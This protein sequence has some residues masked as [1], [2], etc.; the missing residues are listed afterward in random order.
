MDWTVVSAL[1]TSGL[2]VVALF[3]FLSQWREARRARSETSKLAQKNVA[4]AVDLATLKEEFSGLRA[5][6]EQTAV[7][8]SLRES[9]HDF[10]ER[11]TKLED[12]IW[13]AMAVALAAG[14]HPVVNSGMMHIHVPGLVNDLVVDASL[15]V[16]EL[17]DGP[18]E[19]TKLRTAPGGVFSNLEQAIQP[20]EEQGLVKVVRDFGAEAAQLTEKGRLLARILE[21]DEER[22]R[23]GG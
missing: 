20:A 17:R 6:S 19:I 4:S 21:A 16:S 11:V 18:V 1:A 12:S 13:S 7:P 10:E 15:L 22:L 5:E 3:G 9:L 2:F 14:T 8:D 23:Q